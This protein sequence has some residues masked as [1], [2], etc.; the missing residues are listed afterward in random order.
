VTHS[1]PSHACTVVWPGMAEYPWMTGKSVG[2]AFQISNLRDRERQR[3]KFID[4]QKL[5]INK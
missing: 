3:E 1:R 4:N 2:A 5:T